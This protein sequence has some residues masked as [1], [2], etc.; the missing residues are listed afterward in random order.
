M[1]GVYAARG[2]ERAREARSGPGPDPA[3][4]LDCVLPVAGERM[5][6]PV[7][8]AALPSDVAGAC[9]RDEAGAVLWVNGR[10]WPPRQRF[11][12]AHEIGHVRCGH[13][14]R[15]VDSW[16]TLSGATTSAIEVQANAF[17]AEFLV[18]RAGLD[19]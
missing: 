12:L 1:A 4:P 16:T 17:A 8:V 10:E 3:A 13:D 6:L 14:G 11:T 5:R 7:V 18:P 2:A 15:L 19:E 9:Y